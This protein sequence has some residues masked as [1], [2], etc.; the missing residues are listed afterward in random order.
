ELGR[1]KQFIDERFRRI[2]PET[3]WSHADYI[4]TMHGGRIHLDDGYKGLNYVIQRSCREILAK[5]IVSVDEYLT[6]EGLRDVYQ[7]RLPVHDELIF[8]VPI[9]NIDQ[10]IIHGI[11]KRM[12]EAGAMSKVPMV[13]EPKLATES[14]A[15]KEK[16]PDD[17]G[18]DGVKAEQGDRDGS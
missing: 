1:V 6:E 16:C 18:Y 3:K 17:W 4:T 8:Q 14:W 7:M 5:A 13:V 12:V 15:I 11:C 2:G 10:G 9:T